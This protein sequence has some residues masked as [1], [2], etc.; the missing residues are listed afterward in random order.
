[1]TEHSAPWDAAAYRTVIAVGYGNGR[2]EVDFADG[3]HASVPVDRLVPSGSP[4][5]V[6]EEVRHGEHEVLVPRDGEPE[7]E[8]SWMDVR[9]QDDPE[10]A[11][12]LIQTADEEARRVGARLRALRESKGMTSKEVAEAAGIA[13]M[14]LSRI[15]LGRHDVVYRT[16]RKILAA[17]GLGLHDLAA[18]AEQPL[19]LAAIEASLVKAGVTQRLVA[20]LSSALD[21]QADRLGRASEQIF[22]WSAEE[23]LAGANLQ[24]DSGA[25]AQGHFKAAVNQD[26]ALATYT[27]WAY[28]LALIVDQAIAREPVELPEN[29][30]AIREDILERHGR[31]RFEELL[32]WCWEQ[33]VAVVPLNDPGEFHGAVWT[34]EGRAVVVLKQNTPW[35]SRWTFDLGHELAHLARHVGLKNPAVVESQEIDPVE[36]DDDDEQEA[37]DFAGELLLGR[38]DQ[39]AHEL[40]ER[41]EHSLPRLKQEV[42][43]LAEERD[44]EVD[45]LAN[46]MAWR[47]SKEGEDWWGTAGGLQ[48]DSNRAFALAR[49]MLISRVDW[50]QLDDDDSALLKAALTWEAEE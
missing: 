8:I 40:A 41:A 25:F 44:I 10:F 43:R 19:E 33:G 50:T 42:I 4:E 39:L 29:P 46:Y 47:L 14:S 34:I 27:L 26:P 2:L 18:S 31:L 3:G 45:A 35:E 11:E 24:L 20:R 37:S 48:D 23:L 13:P 7:L 9:A 1:M 5:P 28:W 36:S 16:L 12:F 38:P 15:E 30:Y 21:R 32:T 6:W 49:E 22:G 17:M